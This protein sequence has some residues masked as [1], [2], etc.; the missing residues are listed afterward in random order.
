MIG[1]WFVEIVFWSFIAML[2]SAFLVGNLLI[3]SIVKNSL[4]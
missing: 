3:A 1:V 4:R 2:L